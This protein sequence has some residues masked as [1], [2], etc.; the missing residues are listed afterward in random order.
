MATTKTNIKQHLEWFFREKPQK[1]SPNTSSLPTLTFDT[2]NTNVPVIPKAP[3]TKAEASISDPE[4]SFFDDFD[5]S[6]AIDLTCDVV[7]NESSKKR[8][9]PEAIRSPAAPKKRLSEIGTVDAGLNSK[10]VSHMDSDAEEFDDIDEDFLRA[11]EQEMS[12]LDKSEPLAK[13]HVFL[14]PKNMQQRGDGSLLHEHE[15]YL[16]KANPPRRTVGDVSLPSN[17][18]T[19]TISTNNDSNFSGWSLQ[20]LHQYLEVL[21]D[22]KSELSDRIIEQMERDPGSS[23]VQVWIAKRAVMSEKIT[24]V[25]RALGSNSANNSQVVSPTLFDEAHQIQSITS[26]VAVPDHFPVRELTNSPSTTLASRFPPTNYNERETIAATPAQANTLP[27]KENVSFPEVEEF[28]DI[29]FDSNFP[30][31]THDHIEDVTPPDLGDVILIDDDDDDD[32]SVDV[33]LAQQTSINNSLQNLPPANS[34]MATANAASSA[35]DSG[36]KDGDVAHNVIIPSPNDP[37]MSYPWSRELMHTLR[38]KFQ[39]KGFRKNQIE[40]INGTL[41]GKDVF[42]LMPT[43]G[44]KSLCYQLPAVMETGNSRGVTLVISPLLSLMQDQLEHLR[45]LN[46]PALPLSGEQPSDERKQVIS[47]LMAKKVQVKLLYVTPEGLASNGAISR[48]LESLYTRKLLARIVID[49]AHCVSH[50]GH[51]FRPDYKQLGILRDKY[52]GVPVMALTATANEIVKKDVITTLRMENCIE[53]K[54]SF[55]RPNLYYEI[56]P[57]KDVFAEMHRFIS[58]GRLDQSG[59]IYCLSRT[60]CEQVAAKLRNE[61]GLKAWHYHAGLD[62]AER[63]R[64]QSSWQAG[65]Y[66]VIVATIAFGMGVDKGDVRYVIHHSFPKSLE[67]YYQETGRAGRDGKPAHC[68][69]FY[70]YKDSIT[71]Q[72]LITSGE[73]D[74]ETKERQ[75]QMLRQVIQF[76]EN[77]SDCRRKQILS[78]FGESFDKALCNRGCDICCEG[79][80]YVKKDMSS[81]AI[82]AIGLLKRISGKTTL[83]QLMDIFRGSRSARIVENGW[84]RIEGAGDGKT[85]NRGDTERL[86]HQLVAEGVFMERVEA[87]RRGF[88]SAYVIPGR[89]ATVNAVLQ[90]R[91]K[92]ILE[93]KETSTSNS[94]P[95]R[96]LTRS[97]SFPLRPLQR[98]VVE[99]QSTMSTFVHTAD[100]IYDSQLPTTAPPMQPPSRINLDQLS[101]QQN[102]TAYEI[103]VMNRCLAELKQLRSNLMALNDVR[104]SY[105]FTDTMLVDMAMKLPRNIS[106]LTNIHGIQ[107]DRAERVGPQFLKVIEKYIAEKEENLA[108]TEFSSSRQGTVVEAYDVDADDI[109]RDG[110]QH[111]IASD[112]ESLYQPSSSLEEDD[113]ERQSILNFMNSQTLVKP[114]SSSKRSTRTSTRGRGVRKTTSRSTRGRSRGSGSS[115]HWRERSSSSRKASTGIRAMVKSNY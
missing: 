109:P 69:M 60:S 66:K 16:A 84:D 32:S 114:S 34:H 78:Y 107:R 9:Y 82:K 50:W 106:E 30:S 89:Q 90:G 83:L 3:A 42:V 113:G 29:D 49:E 17:A 43:G 91:Q 6:H 110:W 103:D 19:S 10:T 4:T 7:E 23:K 55:N 31:S 101:M 51:D 59:I 18:K 45:K 28:D 77:K 104:V 1:I 68:I 39:L 53:M 36:T 15:N 13:E 72:K 73:G 58:N 75:R 85:L 48:V 33:P 86:F 57:K 63:Q 22:E 47:F 80:T 24:A 71:F 35:H 105:Y 21:R 74:A 87:N 81:Y 56:K 95:A 76:C 99:K 79:A 25:K 97:N 67:G 88:V 93:I 37:Q 108:D 92:V 8:A 14:P 115:A 44:G 65:I 5:D 38:T 40:A 11:A 64:I 2:F 112:S 46:I 26:S 94:A 62:K 20:Q 102:M 52:R 70:S 100:E 54:S 111:D 98:Q 61:Y 27:V 96:T 41:A 12:F